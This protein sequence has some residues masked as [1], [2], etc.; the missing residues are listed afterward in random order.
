MAHD[1]SRPAF[2]LRRLHG[3]GADQSAS[4]MVEFAFIAPPLLFMIMGI[5]Q[6]GLVFLT[7]LALDNAATE[8]GRQVRTGEAQKQYPDLTKFREAI[9]REGNG[10]VQCN[11]SDLWVD[12]QK[13]PPGPVSLGWPVDEKGEFKDEGKYEPGKGGDTI[14]VRVFYRYPVWLPMVGAAMANLPNGRRLIVSSAA[15]RNEP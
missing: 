3:F 9:C 13:L 10:L 2:L 6:V 15:F 1:V 5:F 12:V 7:S 8:L 14:L 4:T 11:T